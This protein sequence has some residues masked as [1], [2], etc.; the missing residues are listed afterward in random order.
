MPNYFEM[1]D[2]LENAA[3]E[4]ER[5]RDLLSVTMSVVFTEE[6]QLIPYYMKFESVLAAAFDKVIEQEH[7][8]CDIAEILMDIHKEMKECRK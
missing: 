6:S 8:I 7:V 4:L 2:N 3:V 5:V 1:S